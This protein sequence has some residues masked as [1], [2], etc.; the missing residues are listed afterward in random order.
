MCVLLPAG[1]T[2]GAC[3]CI[4]YREGSAGRSL[5]LRKRLMP[6]W[7]T[8]ATVRQKEVTR[9]ARTKLRH[10]TVNRI[11]PREIERAQFRISNAL[12]WLGHRRPGRGP[13]G[14][15]D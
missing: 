11:K 7:S 1:R 2:N 3:R 6:G 9:P 14:T 15:G 4:T 13:Q 12:R 10:R 8:M 5:L